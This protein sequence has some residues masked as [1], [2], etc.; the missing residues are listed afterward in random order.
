[1]GQSL[2]INGR[3]KNGTV[4]LDMLPEG[5]SESSVK[6]EFVS[7]QVGEARKVTF[8]M[9]KKAGEPQGSDAA[10]DESTLSWGYREPQA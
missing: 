3:Y 7:P 8:G 2:T 9:L 1:M 6:V 5:I 10:V 4:T